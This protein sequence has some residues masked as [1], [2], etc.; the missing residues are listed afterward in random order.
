[1]MDEVRR[2]EVENYSF[3]AHS[4]D[5]IFLPLDAFV[6]QP[7]TFSSPHP[8]QKDEACILSFLLPQTV[9]TARMCACVLCE[10]VSL[11]AN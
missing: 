7:R 6:S 5:D 3:I 4:S 8:N 2:I 1:M 11:C 10:Y 9:S